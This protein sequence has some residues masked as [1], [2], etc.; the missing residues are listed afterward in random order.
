MKSLD[1]DIKYGIDI[2]IDI[3]CLLKMI[4]KALLV[5]LLDSKKRLHN[6]LIVLILL[7][8]LKLIKIRYPLVASEKI[9][10]KCSK[11]GVTC[12]KPSSGSNTVC[13]VG[14]L[15]GINLIPV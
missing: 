10:N 1:L 14:E 5:L 6:S 3:V 12:T 4:G 2:K 11:I 8:G 9:G 15:L 13:L 7:E